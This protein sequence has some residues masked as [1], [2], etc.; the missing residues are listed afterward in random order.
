M[1]VLMQPSTKMQGR[2]Y[3]QERAR[4]SPN[5]FPSCDFSGKE[6]FE[7]CSDA[8]SPE[9]WLHSNKSVKCWTRYF[10]SET[11]SMAIASLAGSTFGK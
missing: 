11:V 4:T 1:N 9:N 6:K 8:F 3:E 2:N 5:F 7:H 10:N